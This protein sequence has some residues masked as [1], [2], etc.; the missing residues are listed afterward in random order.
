MN[1]RI[2]SIGLLAEADQST[3]L[4]ALFSRR[5]VLLLLTDPSSLA[6]TDPATLDDSHCRA[7]DSKGY[8]HDAQHGCPL[9]LHV[10]RR[11]QRG[12]RD[13]DAP[14]DDDEDGQCEHALEGDSRVG[15][16]RV[17]MFDGIEMAIFHALG[18]CSIGCSGELNGDGRTQ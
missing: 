18:L 3:G 11:G 15:I 16:G 1:V 14:D 10:A 17:V 8:G 2:S 6:S 12:H 4:R 5:R 9:R 13:D 7:E